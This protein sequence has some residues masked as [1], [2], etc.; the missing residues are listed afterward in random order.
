MISVQQHLDMIATDAIEV[1]G[2]NENH[3]MPVVNYIIFFDDQ[4]RE[5]EY[6]TDEETAEKR[7]ELVRDNWNCHLFKRVKSV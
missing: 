3:I 7:L 2:E 6:F 5:P 1:W 4:D